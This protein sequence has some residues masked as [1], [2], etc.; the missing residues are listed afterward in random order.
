M[1]SMSHRREGYKR[2]FESLSMACT[3]TG[4]F[5]T[6]LNVPGRTECS[7][8]S[9]AW[10]KCKCRTRIT[11]EIVWGYEMPW[12]VWIATG[13]CSSVPVLEQ[14]R[15]TVDSLT[16][17]VVLGCVSLPLYGV[18]SMKSITWT[19]PR[20]TYTMRSPTYP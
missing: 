11:T 19:Q 5:K 18:R 13:A 2:C 10:S 4:I 9:T 1:N 20:C 12:S 15:W 16:D 3:R 8:R 6:R 17:I 7:I 14:S